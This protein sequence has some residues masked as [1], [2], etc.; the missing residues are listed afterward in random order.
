MTVE[1]TA[2]E[3]LGDPVLL[4]KIDK[5]IACNVGEYIDLPQLVVVGDQSS[6][7]SSVLEGLTKLPFPRNSGLCTRFATLITFQ[8]ASTKS[9]MVSIRPFE[10]ARRDYIERVKAWEANLETLCA[11]SFSRIMKEVHEV[12]GLSETLD[13]SGQRETFSRDVLQLKI[14]GPEEDHLTVIDV[15]GIFK[16]TTEGITSKDDINMVR[17]MVYDYMKNPRSVILTVVPANVDIATQEILEIAKELDPEGGRTL[18][19]LTKPDLVDKGAEGAIIDMIKGKLKRNRVQWSVL[20]NPGQQDL[21][22]QKIGRDSE[23]RFFS[24]VSPWNS[25]EKD[26]VGIEALRIRL[27]EVITR[28]TRREFPKV[29][30]EISKRL[31]ASRQTLA[32]LGS[33]RDTPEKQRMFLLDIATKFQKITSL[34]LMSNY[35]ADELFDQHEELRIATK[36]AL[37]SDSFSEQLRT[38][39][40]KYMFDSQPKPSVSPVPAGARFAE[41]L[42][43]DSNHVVRGVAERTLAIKDDCEDEDDYDD[44]DITTRTT[45]DIEDLEEIL[46]PDEGLQPPDWNILDW[47]K[48]TYQGSR[49]FE[50]GTFGTGLLSSIM[51]KQSEKWESL[52]FGYISDIVVITHSF[53]VKL[54]ESICIDERVKSSIMSVLID[55]LMERYKKAF[56]QV[57][58]LLEIERLGPPATLNHYFNDNLTKSRQDRT[59]TALI[60]KSFG[61]SDSRAQSMIRLVDIEPYQPMSNIDHAVQDIHDILQAYYKVARKRFVDNVHIQAVH[62]YLIT[63]PDTP[64]ALF[65]ASYILR[66]DEDQL[67]MVAGEDPVTRRLRTTLTKE[68]S[69]LEKGKRILL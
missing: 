62:Y 38:C 55:E 68:I 58:F 20:L 50:V 28:H 29:K 57:Q 59:R 14:C 22:N 53:V 18:G 34:A 5:L 3:R 17:D 64:L 67:E 7:K 21:L 26:R 27:Q 15:P 11:E 46:R 66:L 60:R 63:G 49:G 44:D 30:L 54:L 1:Q 2:Y 9:I 12:M 65:Q 56:Q 45:D 25:L 32:A 37:R 33:E 51:K 24:N 40:H 39:G 10:N 48:H 6:G 43:E 23:E 61:S 4:E 41:D 31:Q 16:N 52:A 35:G 42:E 19:V 69:K 8:R 47:L 36:V 13:H